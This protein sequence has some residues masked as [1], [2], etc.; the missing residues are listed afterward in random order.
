M[1][2]AWVNLVGM[3]VVGGAVLL[4]WLLPPLVAELKDGP[5][6]RRAAALLDRLER[7]AGDPRVPLA[8]HVFP[9]S[10]PVTL[11]ETSS[12]T[13][14]FVARWPTDVPIRPQ[15]A[16]TDLWA[17]LP[18]RFRDDCGT[19]TPAGLREAAAAKAVV[20]VDGVRV[21]WRDPTVDPVEVV[22]A[23]RFA[24]RALSDP[25][26]EDLEEGVR[27]GAERLRGANLRE[28]ARRDPDRARALAAAIDAAWGPSAHA[29]AAELRRD[30][31]TLGAL[32]PDPRSRPH[33]LGALARFREHP[34]PLVGVAESCRTDEAVAADFARAVQ[35]HPTPERVA[36]AR[37]LVVGGAI[38]AWPPR[39]AHLLA[40]FL[41]S[42]WVLDEPALLA[43]LAFPDRRASA[44]ERLAEV[45]SVAAVPVLRARVA[46]GSLP[47]DATE[48]VIA[49]IQARA[50]GARGDLAIAQ[51]TAGAL[52][53]TA[54]PQAV[55]G[56]LS[57]RE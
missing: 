6:R 3:G 12:G 13:W 9:G 48:R 25:S 32:L 18:E 26:P 20:S 4:R 51:G 11:E 24:C 44:L 50:S 54:G 46:A 16:G 22:A 14:I 52:S 27:R 38:A 30:F 19:V 47:G 10:P 1:T 45:G 42:Q 49:A 39:A 15:R 36:F 35:A 29:A 31:A 34:D 57:V 8:H 28:L 53:E 21:H 43:L 55:R 5:Q 37:E 17:P 23:V 40:T 7:A 56:R 2:D 33:A 41:G